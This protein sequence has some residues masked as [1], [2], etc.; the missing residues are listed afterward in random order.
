M[1]SFQ[2]LS[3]PDFPWLG[4]QIPVTYFIP[5]YTAPARNRNHFDESIKYSGKADQL[6][7]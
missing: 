3:Y 1:F 5:N 4:I 7:A 2:L 6:S